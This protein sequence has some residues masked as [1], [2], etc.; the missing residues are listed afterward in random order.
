MDIDIRE[1]WFWIANAV[2]SFINNRVMA[3]D[4]CK[5]VFCLQYLQIKWMNFSKVVSSTCYVWPIFNR[6]MALD[7]RQNFVYA[8]YLVN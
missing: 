1:E 3:L 6:V 2:I 4:L 5:N 7:Q 8:Q